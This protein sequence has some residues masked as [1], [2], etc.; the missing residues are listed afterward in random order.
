MTGIEKLKQLVIEKSKQQRYFK[1][2]NVRSRDIH[3]NIW[4]L[5]TVYDSWI[6]GL[7]KQFFKDK[8]KVLLFVDNCPA[9]LTTFLHELKAMRVVYLPLNMTPKLQPMNSEVIKTIKLQYRKIIC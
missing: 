2:K 4:M 3:K 5:S 7:D 9:H 1:K 8:R 6:F